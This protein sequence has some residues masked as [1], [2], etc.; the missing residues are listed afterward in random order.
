MSDAVWQVEQLKHDACSVL[1]SE[2]FVFSVMG[3][4]LHVF[5]SPEPPLKTVSILVA[6]YSF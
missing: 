5:T 3:V 1:V 2:A 4:W 6:P